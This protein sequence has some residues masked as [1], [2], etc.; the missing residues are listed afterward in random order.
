MGI[1]VRA[2]DSDEKG[3]RSYRRRLRRFYVHG[4]TPISQGRT[5]RR[6]RAISLT[7]A[8]LAAVAAWWTLT[9][10]AALR[11]S[12]A[13]HGKATLAVRT[14]GISPAGGLTGAA[15]LAAGDS[16]Q[17]QLGTHQRR[18]QAG[19]GRCREGRS[20]QRLAPE[21]RADRAG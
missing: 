8:V 14:L 7:I 6:L 10:A 9:A 13:V 4:R 17:R 12:A 21:Q 1:P 16:L 19:G 11:P 5:R 20:H 18:Q 15:N 3:R 2:T